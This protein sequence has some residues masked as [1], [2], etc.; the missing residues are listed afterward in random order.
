MVFSTKIER[1]RAL[2]YTGAS[3]SII[4]FGHCLATDDVSELGGFMQLSGPT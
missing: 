1:P 4:Y 3:L 2:S